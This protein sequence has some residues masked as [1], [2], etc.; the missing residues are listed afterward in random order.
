MRAPGGQRKNSGCAR[1]TKLKGCDFGYAVGGWDRAVES[2]AEA[3]ADIDSSSPGAVPVADLMASSSRPIMCSLQD[4][5]AETTAA[6]RVV[7]EVRCEL[8]ASLE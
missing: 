6:T 3:S 5:M 7:T 4:L 2:S 8:L 1:I